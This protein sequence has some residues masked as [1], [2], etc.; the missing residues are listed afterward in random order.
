MKNEV[1]LYQQ[2]KDL[3][4]SGGVEVLIRYITTSRADSLHFY[5]NKLPGYRYLQANKVI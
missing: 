4:A 2:H 1:L 5:K 3:E